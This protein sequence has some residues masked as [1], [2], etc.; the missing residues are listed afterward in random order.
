MN[1]TPPKI[2]TIII[3]NSLYPLLHLQLPYLTI[4][5][6]SLYNLIFAYSKMIQ[7]Q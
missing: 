7:N 3:Y 4:Y 5:Y 1:A 6:P 2:R